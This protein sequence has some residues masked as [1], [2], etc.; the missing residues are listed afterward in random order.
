MNRPDLQNLPEGLPP[1]C[2]CSGP[3]PSGKQIP[4]HLIY[5]MLVETMKRL[6][7]LETR[8]DYTQSFLKIGD[9]VDED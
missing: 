2:H 1:G 8:L 9:F 6:E 4:S 3:L 5:L 7:E